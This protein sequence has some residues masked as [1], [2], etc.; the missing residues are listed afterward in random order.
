[1]TV[2]PALLA[3]LLAATPAL[4]ADT[5]VVDKVHSDT[6]FTV[7]HLVSKVTG[8]FGD[9]AG[10]INIDRDKPENSSVEFTIKTASIDTKEA[11]RDNHLRS[12]DFFD[13][14]KNPEIT[15]KSAKV[16]AT[17]KDTYDVTGTFTLHGV[18]K[19]ITLPVSF[20]GSM[21]DPGG[22]EKLGFETSTT[23]NRKDYGVSWNRTLDAGGYLLGDDVKI[24]ISIEAGRKKEAP[25]AAPAK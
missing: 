15:F 13:A 10:T 19:E 2:R 9:F 5:Y 7:R 11:K 17:G 25:P 20:L 24:T 6:V 12:P 22:E 16:K 8:R 18:A 1:M 23:L 14:E 4:A 3:A 21:K